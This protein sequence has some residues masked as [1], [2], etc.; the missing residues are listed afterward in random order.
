MDDDA[1][2][3]TEPVRAKPA[4]ASAVDFFDAAPA[5][6]TAPLA[7]PPPPPPPPPP[8]ELPPGWTAHPD[9]ATGATYYWNAGTGATSWEVPTESSNPSHAAFLAQAAAKTPSS[10][11]ISTLLGDAPA[12]GATDWVKHSD[13][14]SGVPY[15]SNTKTSATTWDPP[16]EGFVDATTQRT[17]EVAADPYAANATFNRATGRFEYADGGNHWDARGIH[18]DSEGRQLAHYFDLDNLEQNRAD[19]QAKQQK[20]KHK[21]YD[22]RK[23]KAAKK[24]VKVKRQV[25]KLLED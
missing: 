20:L 7:P 23:Y 18:R 4:R 24:K 17:S 9:Q 2:P 10:R 11:Y 5:D 13:A 14:T 15:F 1:P 6:Q 8:L 19:A 25:Q 12:T 21:K 16:P 22:W 3:G